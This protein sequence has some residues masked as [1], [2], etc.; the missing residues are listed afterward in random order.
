MEDKN[1]DKVEIAYMNPAT[2]TPRQE[3]GRDVFVLMAVCLAIATSCF[4][5][6]IVP[7][8]IV[9]LLSMGRAYLTIIAFYGAF[10]ATIPVSVAGLIW[11]SVLMF[12]R[13]RPSRKYMVGAILAFLFYA[14][15]GCALVRMAFGLLVVVLP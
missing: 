8:N 11:W 10:I 14:C 13:P 9:S 1:S 15:L 3:R 6:A 12:S 7:R 2:I 4:I 5:W